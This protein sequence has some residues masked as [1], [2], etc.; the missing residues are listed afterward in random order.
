MRNKNEL[1]NR[2]KEVLLQLQQGREL[3]SLPRINVPSLPQV[4]MVRHV[5][6]LPT[7]TQD[8]TALTSEITALRLVSRRLT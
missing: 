3:Q 2:F 7:H 1:Q 5:R 6:R 8:V 4:P